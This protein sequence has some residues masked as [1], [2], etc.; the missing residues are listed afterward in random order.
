MKGGDTET[1]KYSQ[2]AHLLFVDK[3]Q[4][5]GNQDFFLKKKKKK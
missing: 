5:S 1:L 4:D 2:M 3:K